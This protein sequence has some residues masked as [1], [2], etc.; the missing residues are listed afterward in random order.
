M[1]LN[2]YLPLF[3]VGLLAGV[4][5][6]GMCGGIVTALTAGSN[7]HN[8]LA[9]AGYNLGRISSY[10]LA[11]A[12]VGGIGGGVDIQFS[13]LGTQWALRTGLY[14]FANVLLCA[15]GFY[16]LGFTR[17]LA[18]SER[19]GH[20][21]WRYLQPCSRHFLP[22]RSLWQAV[23]LGALWGW[24]PCGLVYSVLATALA[25]GSAQSGAL[26]MLAFGLGTLPN[27]LLTG[28]LVGNMRSLSQQRWLRNLAGALVLGYGLY[29]LYQALA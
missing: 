4:H 10:A 21:L 18:A 14:L 9:Q 12:L 15:L 20:L 5:C 26:L 24:L 3:L 7:T 23:A 11:G 17:I 6:V 13:I 19:L 22:V 27:L 2:H 8:Y 25:A 1:N 29:G 28:I 16:L